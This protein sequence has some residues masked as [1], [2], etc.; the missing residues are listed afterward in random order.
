MTYEGYIARWIELGLCIEGERYID[1][2][3]VGLPKKEASCVASPSAHLPGKVTLPRMQL[4][5]F[6]DICLIGV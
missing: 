1:T 3:L 6:V 4:L 5:P 2:T